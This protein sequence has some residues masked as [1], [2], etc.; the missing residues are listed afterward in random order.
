MW[1]NIEK[2][3]VTIWDHVAPTC[4]RCKH[5]EP[6]MK[7]Q[8]TVAQLRYDITMYTK[9]N[10]AQDGARWSHI[11]QDGARWSHIVQVGARWSHVVQDGAI[12]KEVCL[13]LK[14]VN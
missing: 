9:C 1:I 12:L 6:D 4:A 2:Q 7:D 13:S 11:A 14:G 10:I 3:D 5:F 8:Y